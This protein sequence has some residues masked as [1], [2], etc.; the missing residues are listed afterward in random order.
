MSIIPKITIVGVIFGIIAAILL[1]IRSVGIV[2]NN[3]KLISS[4]GLALALI[5]GV[6]GL[7]IGG[8]STGK[9]RYRIKSIHNYQFDFEKEM[10]IS[11]DENGTPLTIDVQRSAFPEG[12]F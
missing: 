3:K 11:L 2:T 1:V 10:L 5:S 7:T 12:W 6:I 9:I 8:I 4:I